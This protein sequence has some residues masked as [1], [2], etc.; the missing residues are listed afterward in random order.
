MTPKEKAEELINRLNKYTAGL[1]SEY[2]IQVALIC[3]DEILECSP[4]FYDNINI[5]ASEQKAKE[6]SYEYWLEVKQELTT[7]NQ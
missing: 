2:E 1:P 7:L 5:H 4:V 3:V 6:T